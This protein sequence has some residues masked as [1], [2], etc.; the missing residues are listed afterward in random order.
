MLCNDARLRGLLTADE[1]SGLFRDVSETCAKYPRLAGSGS[2][3]CPAMNPSCWRHAKTLRGDGDAT[4]VESGLSSSV[5]VA[6]DS[7]KGRCPDR[8]RDGLARLP[9]TGVAPRDAGTAG[10]V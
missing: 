8:L 6:I 3:N 4:D 10:P 5:L 7:F 9:R 1:S 2:S